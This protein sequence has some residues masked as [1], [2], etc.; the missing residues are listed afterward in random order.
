MDSMTQKNRFPWGWVG[1]GCGVVFLIVVAVAVLGVIFFVPAIRTGLGNQSP[2]VSPILPPGTSPT[3]VP[4]QGSGAG[5]TIA[6]LP[7][8]FSSVTDTLV[9]T[10]QSL[11]D[12]MVSTLSLNND[13]DFMAPK[14]YKG[15]TTLDPTSSFTLGNGWCA[16]DDATLKQN[17]ANI[18]YSFSI[19]GTNIDLSKYPMIYFT[20][21]QG[22]SCAITGISITPEANISGSFQMVLTQK[23]TSSVDDGITGT[24]YPAGDVTF[25]FTVQFSGA[26]PNP[27]T[28]L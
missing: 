14:T 27:G 7:F 19:N 4:N 6:T 1:L 18:H 21:N 9:L 24:P 23:F 26:K 13:T 20:D 12:Q 10:N 16:K 8:K 2:A 5:T 15:T 28:T 3:P 17:L 11:V 22:D 25:D